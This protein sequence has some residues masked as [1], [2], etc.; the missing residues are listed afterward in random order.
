MWGHIAPGV[1][2]VFVKEY[3]D[4]LSIMYFDL[5][6]PPPRVAAQLRRVRRI[7]SDASLNVPPD[8]YRTIVEHVEPGTVD[9]RASM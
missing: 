2:P 9:V 6:H 4:E 7:L 3:D 8:F 5:N 1:A